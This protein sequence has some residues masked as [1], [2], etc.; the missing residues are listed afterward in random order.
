MFPDHFLFP[1]DDKTNFVHDFFNEVIH[2]RSGVEDFRAPV[3][4]QKA[5]VMEL[6]APP[7]HIKDPVCN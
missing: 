7:H 6:F 1:I 4:H 2:L 3:L 5:P